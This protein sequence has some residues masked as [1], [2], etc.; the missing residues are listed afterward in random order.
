MTAQ[1]RRPPGRPR[2][3]IDEA[4]RKRA[5]RARRAAELA[6]PTQLR[7]ALQT[8]RAETNKARHIAERARKQ[9]DSWRG[10]AAVANERAEKARRRIGAAEHAAQR[11]RAERD[12]AERKLRG[13]LRDS[14]DVR[15]LLRDPD[16]LVALVDK[17]RGELK[18]V[19][20]ELMFARELLGYPAN[21]P[22]PGVPARRW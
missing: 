4:E 7:A 3:W 14:S 18:D 22:L 10:R 5:Y 17:L 2:K 11:A 15:A 19:R 8:A 1:P 20:R 13:R 6:E 21:K 16:R 9:A 12:E